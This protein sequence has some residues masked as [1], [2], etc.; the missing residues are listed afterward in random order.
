MY[1]SDEDSDWRNHYGG[2]PGIEADIHTVGGR[3]AGPLDENWSYSA[4]LAKQWGDRAGNTLQALGA[5]SKLNY[6]F[7]DEKQTNVFVGY[8]Y[9]S[10]DDPDTSA[11]EQFDSLWGDWPQSQRGGDLQAYMWTFEGDGI[12]NVMN[13][14]RFGVGHSFKPA[15]KWTM[16]TQYNLLWADENTVSGAQAPGGVGLNIDGGDNFRGQMLTGLLTYQC[17]KNFRT[18]FLVDYFIPGS[19]Y[20]TS[21]DA[22]FARI[23]MEWTF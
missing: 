14:H 17:C 10:G 5:N 23:N 18:Q 21:D 1:K 15:D 4:E 19:Y 8:E 2:A 3:L 7:N 22:L 13:L 16:L 20:N 9:M 12:G 11:D 6:A